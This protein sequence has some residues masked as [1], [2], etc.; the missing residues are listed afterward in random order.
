I[1]VPAPKENPLVHELAELLEQ[2]SDTDP[3]S[4]LKLTLPLK[5]VYDRRSFRVCANVASATHGETVLEEVLGSGDATQRFQAFML[6]QSPLTY[7]RSE[8]A[9]GF[10]STLR[11]RV[12]NMLWHETPT[13]FGTDPLDRVFL[14]NRY[15]GGKTSI[16]FGNQATPPTGSD[17]IRAIYR[18]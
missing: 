8:Q 11:V 5:Y 1:R 4:V 18:K 17:N 15:D 2:P 6:R 3:L 14:I 10:V 12:N 9:L 16:T 13:L 7:W